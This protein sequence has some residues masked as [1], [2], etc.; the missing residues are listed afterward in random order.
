MTRQNKPQS[1][2]QAF[3]KTIYRL[4]L[5]NDNFYDVTVHHINASFNRWLLQQKI[6]TWSFITPCNPQARIHTPKFNQKQIS[7][8]KTLLDIKNICYYPAIHI[9]AKASINQWPD[10]ESFFVFNT[11]RD[12]MIKIAKSFNQKALLL[13]EHEKQITIFWL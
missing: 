2:Q 1:I 5:D 3:E 9:A 11:A 8:L 12:E 10:E 13:G 7:K 4:L 6:S